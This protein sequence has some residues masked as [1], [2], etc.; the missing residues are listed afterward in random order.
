MLELSEAQWN[1]L[2]R[3]AKISNLGGRLAADA[4]A[5][6]IVDQ[7]PLK[8]QDLFKSFRY[9]SVSSMRMI[10]WEM[11]RVR[12]ALRSGDEKVILLK[13]GAYIDRTLKCTRGRV[14][15]DLD[16]LVAK[17]RLDWAEEQFLAA[18]W[19]HH[20]EN[21]YD[22]MFYREY[23][24]ELPPMVH[25]DRQISID[26]HHSILP[27]TSRVY[28][29][30]TKL[31]DEAVKASDGYYTFS[32]VDMFLHSVVHL[33]QDGEVRSSLRNLL[34][35]HDMLEEFG[36]NPEFW[37]KLV[38]RAEELGF[39]RALYYALRYTRMIMGSKIPDTVIA[40]IDCYGPNSISK[41]LMDWM[42]PGVISPTKG[43]KGLR[44]WLSMNGL[45][46]RSHWLRM[47]PMLLC[48]H[49]SIKFMRRLKGEA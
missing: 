7:L 27:V 1:E 18:G 26:V 42:V 23:S 33:W 25:P 3:E 17:N 21:D 39:T 9:R 40:A 36:I 45:Y 32:D 24:H 15:V 49:L 4:D 19:Q 20:L 48:K 30:M 22:Q 5:F 43:A 28:P 11:N 31:I 34:E 6:G 44:R 16:I 35:Q 37:M 13:G 47:P 8:V 38:P 14:S 10:K 12:R 41:M 46:I 29:D 2:F